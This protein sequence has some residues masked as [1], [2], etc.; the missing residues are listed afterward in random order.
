MPTNDFKAFSAGGGANVLTQAQYAALTTLIASGFQTGPA[1]SAQFNKVW[2][3]SS[4]MAAVLGALIGDI[5]GQNAVD[6]GTTGTL[7]SN[8]L[9][10]IMRAGYVDDSGAVNAYAATLVP[11][12]L[13][14]YDGMV[15][16]FSTVNT[17]TITNPTLNVNGLGAVTI[18]GIAGSAL[19]AGQ[20]A[21]NAPLW[22]TYNSTGP[23]FE[24]KNSSSGSASQTFS[25]ARAIASTSVV[26]LSQTPINVKTYLSDA[27]LADVE[28]YTYTLDVT[29]AFQTAIAA[30][31]A[32]KRKLLVPY[33]GYKI[34]DSL[35][36]AA[37]T[38]IEGETEFQYTNG[39]GI[40]P[41]ATTIKFAPTTQKSL[42]VPNDSPASG[43]RFHISVKNLYIE[44]NSVRGGS[45]TSLYAINANAVI[46]SHFENIGITGFNTPIKCTSTINNRFVNV[47]CNGTVSALIYAGTNE[48]TDVWEQCSFWGSPLG[49]SFLGSSLGIRFSKC[50][51]EQIDTYGMD[52]AKECYSIL[53][54]GGYCEDVPFT[55]TATGAMFRVGFTGTT[56]AGP[57][58]LQVIG[59]SYA[60]RNAG[61]IGDFLTVDY[62]NGVLL[63]NVNVSRFTNVIRTTANTTNYA[64][65]ASG[66][67]WLSCTNRYNDSTK[68]SGFMDFQSINA[69]TGT[70]AFFNSMNAVNLYGNLIGTISGVTDASSASAGIVGEYINSTVANVS[71]AATGVWKDLTS[72]TLTAGD[73]D[74]DLTVQHTVNGATVT[75]WQTGVGTASG[76]GTTGLVGGDTSLASAPPVAAYD[77]SLTIARVRKTINSTTTYYAKILSSYTVA[78]PQFNGR[79]SARRI[80]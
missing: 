2:R 24:L 31:Q 80:R 6:D 72:I 49:V 9:A 1:N 78:I 79:I 38:Q 10:A 20:L 33:G 62:A 74:I 63:S 61:I 77:T 27:Q 21:A 22:V 28:A 41:K 14:Y 73:W 3:Q 13:A 69:G 56:L 7:E 60:G 53:V 48:T 4:I 36:M 11:A 59:G 32:T 42:F 15:V 65:C 35:S 47:Y 67:Q 51:W 19:S 34:T 29:T 46:Y 66:I 43:F 68:F 18:T 37:G 76:T 57:T 55:A 40:A 16:G 17:N 25:A 8:L 52:V 70:I 58:S 23:R 5:T 64:V 45:T 71:A 50:L 39:Y 75:L 26:Q 12:V 30:A 54:D 44:G